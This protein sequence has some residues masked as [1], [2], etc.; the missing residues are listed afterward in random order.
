MLKDKQSP[1]LCRDHDTNSF[2]ELADNVERDKGKNISPATKKHHVPMDEIKEKHQREVNELITE[3]KSLDSTVSTLKETLAKQTAKFD[4]E[5]E[6]N[7]K[8][9]NGIIEQQYKAMDILR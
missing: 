3:N 8:S 9:K 1:V 2:P 7:T 6:E 4:L 5:M